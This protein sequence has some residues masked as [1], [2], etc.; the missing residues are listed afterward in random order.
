MRAILNELAQDPCTLSWW[1]QLK[2]SV[3]L[4]APDMR[5]NSFVSHIAP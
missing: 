1:E 3:H 2:L 5:N 4:A